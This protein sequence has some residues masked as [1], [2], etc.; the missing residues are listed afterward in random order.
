MFHIKKNFNKVKKKDYFPTTSFI[1][2]KKAC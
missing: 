2:R 1:R